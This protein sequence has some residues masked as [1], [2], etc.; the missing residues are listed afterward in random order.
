M[1]CEAETSCS[2]QG[3]VLGTRGGTSHTCTHA[4]YACLLPTHLAPGDK[5]W[6]GVCVC[7][8]VCVCARACMQ[9]AAPNPR[10]PQI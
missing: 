5:S 9:R 10:F 2:G 3:F 4:P 7:V 6:R 8:C 1:L